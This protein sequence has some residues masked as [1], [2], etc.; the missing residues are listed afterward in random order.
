MTTAGQR[1][2]ENLIGMLKE[3]MANLFQKEFQAMVPDA[4][5]ALLQD[6][7]LKGVYLALV[8]VFVVSLFN[9][10]LSL[11]LPRK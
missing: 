4:M 5:Q 6:A 10:G 2:P 7:V 3:S 11:L 8:I 9:L 1:L